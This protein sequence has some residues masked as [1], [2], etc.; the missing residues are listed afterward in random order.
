MTTTINADN[1]TFEKNNV[2]VTLATFGDEENLTKTLLVIT[3]PTSTN[4]R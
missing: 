2:V 3:P 1:I 4:Q